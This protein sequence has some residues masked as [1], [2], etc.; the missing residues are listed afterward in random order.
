VL[1]FTSPPVPE[2]ECTHTNTGKGPVC[3]GRGWNRNL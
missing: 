2:E 3:W 1:Q